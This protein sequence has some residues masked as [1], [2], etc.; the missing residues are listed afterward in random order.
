M[1][2]YKETPVHGHILWD[3]NTY[4][5]SYKNN[6][7]NLYS[8]KYNKV[9]NAYYRS[10]AKYRAIVWWNPRTRRVDSHGGGNI[11]LS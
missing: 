7:V 10:Q 1:K 2:E 3:L 4:L 11:F 9:N 6:E 8:Y 5:Y